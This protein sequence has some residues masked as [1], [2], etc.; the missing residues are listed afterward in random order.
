MKEKEEAA[1]FVTRKITRAVANYFMGNRDILYLGNLS[2][3]RD[4]GSAEDY[5]KT[6]W[7]MMQKRSHQI[8]LFR[9]V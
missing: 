5:V 7:L 4:W 8:M 6:M 1:T 3:K 9:Q 2:A